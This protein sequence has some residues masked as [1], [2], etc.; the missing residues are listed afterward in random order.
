LTRQLDLFHSPPSIF[1]PLLGKPA[2]NTQLFRA[3]PSQHLI[4]GREE[5]AK[6]GE[7]KAQASLI[8]IH[9]LIKNKIMESKRKAAV[10][11]ADMIERTPKRVKSVS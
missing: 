3:R 6:Q 11:A 8:T 1:V 4:I 7:K 2:K 9:H 5:R 10:A